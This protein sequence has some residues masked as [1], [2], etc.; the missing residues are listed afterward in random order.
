PVE[1]PVLTHQ[2]IR[3]TCSITL[4]CRGHDLSISS[5]CYKETC[6]EKEVTSPGGVTLSLSVRGSSIICN[7]SNPVSW[8]EDVLEM[9]ELKRLCA[10]G[11]SAMAVLLQLILAL[12]TLLSVTGS[13]DVVRLVG[14]SVQLDIQRPVPE[15]EEL[16]WRFNKT[17]VVIKYYKDTNKT[18]QYPAY[19][20]RVEFNEGTYSLTL[21]NLQKTDSGPY[22][23]TAT[24]EEDTVV[25]VYSLSVLDPVQA[26]VLTHLPFRDT[27][28]LTCRGHDL[29]IN[30]SCH[31]ET[32]EEMEVTSPGGIS[33]S[34]SVKGSSI[35]CNQSN[36]V[37]WKEAVLKM[38]ELKRLCAGGGMSAGLGLPGS[39]LVLY[40]CWFEVARYECW[41]GVA[42]YECW[43]GV[44]RLPAWVLTVSEM[45]M[46]VLQLI[47]VL[48]TLI[49]ITGSSE[50][51]TWVGGS[52]QLDIQRPVL[53]FYDLSWVFNRTDN[54]L[55]YNKKCKDVTSFSHY[56]DRVE[57]NER[58]YTLT[59]KNL[60]K[61]DSGPYEAR[62]SDHKDTVVAVYSLS[63][64]GRGALQTA[65]LGPH[66]LSEMAMMLQMIFVLSTLISITGSSDVFR[67]V[68]GSVQLNIQ[69][70]VPEFDELIWRFN[71]TDNVLKYYHELNKA[72][73]YPGY[74]DRVEFNEGTYSLTLKN[75]QKTDS[76]LYEARTSRKKVT[77]VAEYSL[78][79]LDPVRSPQV[80]CNVTVT[81][82]GHDLSINSSCNQETCN[83]K[84]VTSPGGFTLSLSVR[85]SSVICNYSNPVSWRNRSVEMG[86]LKK[87]C[88]GE[89]EV[90]SHLQAQHSHSHHEE[91]QTRYGTID[92][93]EHTSSLD[94]SSHDGGGSTAGFCPL[95]SGLDL[96]T[97]T[98]IKY[99]IEDKITKVYAAYKDRVEFNN[100]TYSLTLKNL[101]WTDSG[102]YEASASGEKVRA[103]AEYRLSVLGLIQCEN[104]IYAELEAS[105]GAT[106]P[107][108]V[109]THSTLYGAVTKKP[110][111]P[112][113]A[114][115][116]RTKPEQWSTSGEPSVFTIYETLPDQTTC[117]AVPTMMMLL[118]LTFALSTL[119]LISGSSDVFRWVGDSVQM[120]IP[121]PVPEFDD[122]IWVF[123]GT[124][125]IIKYFSDSKKITPN[126]GYEDRVEFNDRTYSLTL[127]N[128]QNTD[129]GLYEA[130]A[131]DTQD[132]VITKY[133]LW[134]SRPVVRSVGESV[135]LDI[136]RPVPEFDE[137]SW[138]FGKENNILKY[139]KDTNKT[140][141]YP[142]YEGRA[143]FSNKTYSLTLKNLQKSDSG[144]YEARVSEKVDTVVALYRLFVSERLKVFLQK[145]SICRSKITC[146]QRNALWFEKVLDCLEVYRPAAGP[147]TLTVSSDVFGL[148]GDSIQLDIQGPVP[149]FDQLFWKFKEKYVVK[150]Y[151][152]PTL[153]KPCA[154]YMDRVEFNNRTYS[155]T[156]KNLQKND[157]GLYEAGASYAK[158]TVVAKHSLTVLDA[159]DAPV[160][161]PALDELSNDTCNINLTC[162]GHDLSISSSCSNETC[163][164]KEVASPGGITLSLSINGSS[165]IC[166]HSNPVSWKEAVLETVE[167]ERLCADGGGTSPLL[168]WLLLGGGAIVIIII[169]ITLIAV[170][171]RSCLQPKKSTV[172]IQME[173]TVYAEVEN[174]DT[175]TPHIA[176]EA[177]TTV[178]SVVETKSP[179]PSKGQSSYTTP[180][181]KNKVNMAVY[182]QQYSI[183]MSKDVFGKDYGMSYHIYA[184]DTQ[185]YLALSQNNYGPLDSL[186]SSDVVRLVG[187]SVQLDIRRPV[188]D[189][190]DLIWTFNKTNTVLQYYHEFK[191]AIQSPGYE[192]RVEFNKG[193][194]SLTLKSLQKTDSGLY[195]ARTSGAQVTFVAEYRLSVLGAIALTENTVYAEV[196]HNSDAPQTV[197]ME[198]P[199]TVYSVVGMQQPPPSNEQSV[200][201]P[202]TLPSGQPG[203]GN[204]YESVPSEFTDDTTVVGLISNKDD[205]RNEVS[206]LASW[207]KHN[208]LSLNAEKTK[209]NSHPAYSSVHQRCCC[210]EDRMEEAKERTKAKY[211]DL[212]ADWR[213]NG[214]K[215]RCE[216]IEV[217]GRGFAGQALHRVLGLLGICGLHR[218]RAM[219][220][221]TEAAEKASRWLWLRKG[222]AKLYWQKTMS[223]YEAKG[224]TRPQEVKVKVS[225]DLSHEKPWVNKSVRALIKSRDEA[226]R[227]GD[228]LAYSAARKNLKKGIKEAKHSYKQRIE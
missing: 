147:E 110:Q 151:N 173:D 156:L 45:A 9:G 75:L 198:H 99:Y 196:Q 78:S 115:P 199:T 14:D 19:K 215:A 83:E 222:D 193:T 41:V 163:E 12:S 37:S 18:R 161:T 180:S 190:D 183:Y 24:R 146:K 120:D 152:E 62:V 165:I 187:D 223:S 170:F 214:W 86:H 17:N 43:V 179:P 157:S 72:R 176:L 122:L 160:L 159:V 108:T 109:E 68:G 216:T 31:N 28:N 35:I 111:P 80:S 201:S 79:V 168:Y 194:Y 39:A 112:S 177:H 150:Y 88:A 127:K 47:F 77:V 73:L 209:E 50:V 44:A 22:Q 11:V 36:P 13:S 52:V 135:Q 40:K 128:L 55:K 221:I 167:L 126:A 30:S 133:Q 182:N 208:S 181:P 192:D 107:N 210:G 134:V 178:Y 212:V 121:S 53:E 16:F 144:L 42:R 227:S 6:E 118:Q 32:C 138:M 162:K 155:L 100:R 102:L 7:H 56:E 113:N 171:I 140:T 71:G 23:A 132:T 139:Y 189:K 166:N 59:L 69:R 5:S 82:R 98:V 219:K 49:S 87:L 141:Q 116:S 66:S 84:K 106:P 74:E 154:G 119:A 85:G 204:T 2:L 188:P 29:S 25:A 20:G 228:R 213:R 169:I 65:C 174:T 95:L 104:T 153:L 93:S 67:P 145:V 130:R 148:V 103:V 191:E 185:V 186:W 46:M 224:S 124:N 10:D 206:R 203:V 27:C 101:Q 96:R 211:A 125:N 97:D 63:V 123:N 58:N 91:F 105:A 220:N 4:T 76:G 205:Y 3:D 149:E 197:M 92:L 207:C 131:S 64:L 57:F 225:H 81:C 34:L 164:E 89:D 129:S 218:R 26:P 142:G 38:E 51:V 8:K 21:K 48:S 54:V 202:E 1:A 137:F 15:F 184:D 90:A 94:T 136:Q 200:P 117:V 226:F 172:V 158:N 61:T 143:E 217:G 114:Q 195:E 175:G 60:Q 33:L 70:P